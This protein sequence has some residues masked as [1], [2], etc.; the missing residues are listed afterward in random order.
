[1]KWNKK[2]NDEILQEGLKMARAAGDKDEVPIGA[3]IFSSKTH[4]IIASSGNMNRC[5]QDPTAH[6]EIEVIR[7]A[8][9]KLNCAKLQGYSIFVTLEPCAMCAMAISLARLDAVYFGAE[10]IKSGGTFHGAKV[11]SHPQTH[12]KPFVQ[13]GLNSEECGTLLSNFFKLKRGK[14][15]S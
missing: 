2:M 4:Q 8:C 9:A 1:M 6:A 15:V 5:K 12:H 10:D 3:V 11:F 7:Q 14:N 13:G